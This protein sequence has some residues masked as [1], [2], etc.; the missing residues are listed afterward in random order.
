MIRNPEKYDEIPLGIVVRRTPGVTRW[1]NWT[2]KAVA[3]LPG[4]EP[5]NWRVLR[6]EGDVVEYHVATVLLELHG[7][8]TEAYLHG[9]SAQVPSVFAVMRPEEDEQHPLSVALVTAS[10]YEAQDYAD[11][12][13][14][15]VEK[16]PMPAGLVSWIQAFAEAHH[17]DEVF[18]KRR[19]D[20]L[21]VDRVENGIGDARIP[22]VVDVYRAPAL[23]RKERLQ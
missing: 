6:Q 21:N 8:D 18:V 14:D 22:Q 15:I 10:P 13:E 19:R 5:A 9:L 11:N 2:W 3:V 20:R 4:A 7:S 1:A 23:A 17:E 12:G 16:I